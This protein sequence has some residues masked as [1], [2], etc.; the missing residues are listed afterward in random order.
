SRRMFGTRDQVDPVR[1]LIGTA[2]GW[3]GNPEK[4]AIYLNVTPTKNDGTTVH[5]LTVKDVPVDGFWAI[6]VY[7]A[8]GY[9]LKNEQNAYTLH[10]ITAKRNADGSVTVQ[11]GGHDGKTPNCLPITPGWNYMVR[12]YRP[13][14]EI[15][16]GTW[17]FPTAEPVR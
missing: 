2:I 5:P 12:L 3:G 1:H 9:F 16:D 6:S 8:A 11:F 10:N 13:R 4:D 17:K 14:K 15:L 7:K